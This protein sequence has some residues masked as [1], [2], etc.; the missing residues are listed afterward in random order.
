MVYFKTIYLQSETFLRNKCLGS[1][2]SSIFY[3]LLS[4]ARFNARPCDPGT[5]QYSAL[6][7]I[8]EHKHII[9][10]LCLSRPKLKNFVSK[11]CLLHLRRCMRTASNT[12][13]G[14]EV[15]LEWTT[16]CEKEV[17]A[18]EELKRNLKDRLDNNTEAVS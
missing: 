6:F 18:N 16:I 8:I 7:G 13:S 4:H 2:E 15:G 9:S 14:K 5:A 10:I 1:V 17:K 12:S 3:A 11:L